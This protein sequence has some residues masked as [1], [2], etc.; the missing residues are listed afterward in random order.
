MRSQQRP[1]KFSA[2][3]EEV[4][5]WA[6]L[7]SPEHDRSFFNGWI[8]GCYPIYAG[9]VTYL[10]RGTDG[11]GWVRVVQSPFKGVRTHQLALA[12]SSA[13]FQNKGKIQAI[14]AHTLFQLKRWNDLTAEEVEEI[15]GDIRSVADVLA[16]S[17][18]RNNRLAEDWALSALDL[19]Q[20]TG[21]EQL[22]PSATMA[23]TSA[24]NA[25]AGRRQLEIVGTQKGISGRAWWA[26]QIDQRLDREASE[27]WRFL[28]TR[29]VLYRKDAAELTEVG[30]DLL[31][32]LNLLVSWLFYE[33]DRRGGEI[34]NPSIIEAARSAFDLHRLTGYMLSLIAPIINLRVSRIQDQAQQVADST[35]NLQQLRG[36]LDNLGQH[37]GLVYLELTDA[38]SNQAAKLQASVMKAHWGAAKKLAVGFEYLLIN[39]C[40]PGAAPQDWWYNFAPEP[41]QAWAVADRR[42]RQDNIKLHADIEKMMEGDDPFKGL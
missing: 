29:E 9:D 36:L 19:T 26:S 34:L 11:E 25:A 16:G 24:G 31:K 39:R 28:M 7:Q 12:K 3:G 15:K 30:W 32:P 18:A 6:V 38:L 35:R 42:D 13:E 22:N 40:L 27:L 20:K 5:L 23:K 17:R 14:N 2:S 21:R 37:Q 41:N 10:R 4:E 8:P 33:L 1:I